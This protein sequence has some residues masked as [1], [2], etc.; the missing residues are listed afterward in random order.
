MTHAKRI[1]STQD[2][3]VTHARNHAFGTKRQESTHR[4]VVRQRQRMQYNLSV[5]NGT[6]GP[7]GHS[8]IGWANIREGWA[9]ETRIVALKHPQA[10]TYERLAV[11]TNLR[12]AM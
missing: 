6:A 4:G 5:G 9:K 1:V 11:P 8:V 3:Q 7:P 2:A 12:N 10:T